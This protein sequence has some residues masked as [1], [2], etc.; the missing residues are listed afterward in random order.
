MTVCFLM[1]LDI[2]TNVADKYGRTPL[3][4]AAAVD[5]PDMVRF[6]LL[7]D[8]SIESKTTE[9]KQTPLHYAA[10]NHANDSLKMLLKYRA[11]IEAK[12]YKER[13]PLQVR[14]RACLL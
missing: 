14:L 12:D 13:T 4:V 2:N 6:L 11:E 8:A 10:R 5:Y 9:E 3:H 1:K 7:R